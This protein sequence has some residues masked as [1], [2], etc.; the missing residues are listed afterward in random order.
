MDLDL[1]KEQKILK[2]SAQ[3]FLKKEC[4]PSLLRE[5][6]DDERGYP[7]KLWDQMVDLGWTGVMIP[8]KYGG[9]GGSYLDLCILLEAMGEVC[10]PGPFFST[11]VLG[12]LTLLSAGTE[13]QKGKYLPR[14]ADGDLI[15]ALAMT[16]PGIWYDISQIAMSATIDNDDFVLN[17]TKLFVENGH[18]A[19]YIICGARTDSKDSSKERFA[20]FLVDSKSPGVRCSFQKNL[21]YDRQCAIVFD[22]VRVPKSHVLGDLGQ[23]SG[24]MERLQEQAAVAKCAELVGCIQTAFDMTVKYAKDRKQFGRPIGSF[25]AVQHHCANMVVDVDGS[26]FMT[27]QAAWKISEGLAASKEAAM[28]K[29]WTSDASRRVTSLAHQIH[30]AISFTEEYD[31]HLFY[32]R[33]KSGEVAFGDAEYHLEKV[34]EQLGL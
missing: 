2:R 1:T 4:P 31:V 10:C 17:G 14:I 28:A 30:G 22:K 12:G 27:Y 23:A 7:Q 25:Q 3:D 19:D 9:I 26:R 33:A 13:E 6:K 20:L 24:I 5:M 18:I 11:V 29:A 34:A 21:G 8:E 32:R 16:E 15:F